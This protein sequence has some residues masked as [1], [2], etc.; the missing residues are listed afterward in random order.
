MTPQQNQN[1]SDCSGCA[2]ANSEG[3]H[4]GHSRQHGCV[5]CVHD[6]DKAAE[7][8]DAY[9]SQLKPSLREKILQ[10][11]KEKFPSW[12]DPQPGAG[13]GL[14]ALAGTGMYMQYDAD[15]KKRDEEIAEIKLF[16]S[17]ALDRIAAEARDEIKKHLIEELKREWPEEKKRP[18]N[19]D[20]RE[21]HLALGYNSARSDY[22]EIV[23]KV[24]NK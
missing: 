6:V 22:W 23:E 17:S 2:D 18:V 1:L 5:G 19:D 4:S 13:D 21:I 10:E 12:S 9:L 16:F 14:G 11:F 8:T 24:L 7:A 3:T 15:R 20:D